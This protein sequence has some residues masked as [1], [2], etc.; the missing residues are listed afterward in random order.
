MFTTFWTIFISLE[1]TVVV[2]CLGFGVKE[3][4][5]LDEFLK[6]SDL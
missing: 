4:R 3:T 1:D 5:I 2:L 6:L